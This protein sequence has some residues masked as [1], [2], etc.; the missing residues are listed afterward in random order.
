MYACIILAPSST[1]A[2]RKSTLSICENVTDPITKKALVIAPKRKV[3]FLF[4]SVGLIQFR[5]NTNI[6]K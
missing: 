5:I 1:P 3:K 4:M 6:E 2:L